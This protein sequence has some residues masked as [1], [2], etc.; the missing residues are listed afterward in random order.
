MRQGACLSVALDAVLKDVFLDRPENRQ[1]SFLGEKLGL[2]CAL[3][4]GV[5]PRAIVGRLSVRPCA[6]NLT[7]GDRTGVV[8]F[9]V[10]VVSNNH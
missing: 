10:M 3:E 2:E 5:G 9:D 1:E 4:G 8:A 7:L 6:L